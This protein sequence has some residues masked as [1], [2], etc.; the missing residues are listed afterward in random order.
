MRNRLLRCAKGVPV[1]AQD[2]P[3]TLR[4][5]LYWPAE[6]GGGQWWIGSR[7][8]PREAGPTDAQ[9]LLRWLLASAALTLFVSVVVGWL[10]WRGTAASLN[11]L[12]DG[13]QRW[14]RQEWDAR[15]HLRAGDAF[16]RLATA[17]NHMA[18]RIGE[19]VGAIRV[20]S[21]ID[22]E[23][24]GGLDT[25]RIMD[26][27]TTRM[28]SLQPGAQV[29]VVLLGSPGEPWSLHRPGQ[30]ARNMPASEALPVLADGEWMGSSRGGKPLPWV[31]QAV[32]ATAEGL[33][34]VCW[35]PALW[36]GQVMALLLMCGRSELNFEGEVRRELGELRDRV[37]VTLAAAARES[38]LL[39]RAV[40]D[41]LTG[42]LNRN[43]LHDAIDTW[44]SRA[45]PFALVLVDLDRFKEVNDTL[46]HQAG[47]E[48]LCAVAERLRTCVS[49]H[50]QI[51]RP[52]GDEFVLL[53]PGSQ[54]EA[55]AAAMAICAELGRPFPLRGVRQQIGGSL[56]LAAFPQ[57]AQSRGELM[58]RADLAMYVSKGE[59]RGRFSWYASVMDERIAKRSWMA[60]ELRLAIDKADFELWYQPRVDAVSGRIVSAEALLRWPHAERGMIPP[61]EFVPAAEETGLI[62]RLGQWVLASAFEQMR[63]WRAAGMPIHRVAVNVSPRQ[64]KAAGFADMVLDL[65]ARYG[66]AATDIEL[67]LT[68]SVFAG[69]VDAVCKVLEPLRRAGMQL[70][71]DDFGTGYSSLSSLYRLP[72]DVIKID[73]S[74][75]RD[76]GIRPSAEIMARSIVALAKALRKR[77][78][79]EGVE[80]RSQRDHLLRLDCDE[81]QGYL[82]AQPLRVPQL[83]ALFH[84][85]LP[86]R[87]I[88]NKVSSGGTVDK[89]HTP[90]QAQ[91]PALPQPQP[92]PQPPQP[93]AISAAAS[94][95]AASPARRG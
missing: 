50:A 49:P 6:M 56:G 83:E 69:D 67:E 52:G 3:N 59:G 1:Q 62:D 31:T 78:V 28:T 4:R 75:V 79:A 36:Q 93:M 53:L 58:R 70:A 72:V 2:A 8:G 45:Q 94:P 13:T 90:L 43:G 41:G 89:A 92:Q 10:Q 63:R 46:G 23:I 22:R 76:L 40:L 88:E 66:L 87:N 48:L 9:M 34:H 14:A 44:L 82:Y 65:L 12:I 57:H 55:A 29:A 47:D 19:Q 7:A 85:T 15:V 5:T 17:L 95:R 11:R 81:L 24:L 37:A 64:L 60:H 42:L 54:Q 68:E 27:V 80:T 91:L 86:V 16:G 73:Y 20:Q 35:I 77:V 51:A 33:W 21:A 39:E 61:S 71:L 32:P 84:Q 74:F 26:L 30:A 38:A 25:A 18:E